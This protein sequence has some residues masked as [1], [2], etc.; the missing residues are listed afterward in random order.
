MGFYLSSLAATSGLAIAFVALPL[1]VLLLGAMRAVQRGRPTLIW[2]AYFTATLLLVL[3]VLVVAR[4][5]AVGPP[6][7]PLLVQLVVTVL[8]AAFL[9]APAVAA[10]RLVRTPNMTLRAGIAAAVCVIVAVVAAPFALITVGCLLT[11]DC[12]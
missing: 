4:A 2:A 7:A 12:L 11:G 9:L 5:H 1:A 10:F 3:L 8:S 6:P